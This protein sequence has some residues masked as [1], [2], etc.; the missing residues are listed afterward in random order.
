MG[1]D[2]PH[3]CRRVIS[4]HRTVRDSPCFLGTER[5]LLVP[6]AT[7]TVVSEEVPTTCTTR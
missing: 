3:D 6:L 5:L 4:H 7:G 1:A 2:H